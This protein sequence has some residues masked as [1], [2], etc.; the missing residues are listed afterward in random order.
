MC[1]YCRYVFT[2]SAR[3]TTFPGFFTGKFRFP[4]NGIW[5]L[6]PLSWGDLMYLKS[7]LR[8]TRDIPKLISPLYN[9]HNYCPQ[10]QEA[11]FYKYQKLFNS[12]LEV[13]TYWR[14]IVDSV[15]ELEI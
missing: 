6:R 15:G 13:L 5:E 9:C 1:T 8:A 7:I 10:Q 12:L 11:I 2:I 4:G 14:G 3:D